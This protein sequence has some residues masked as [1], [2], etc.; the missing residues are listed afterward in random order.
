MYAIRSYYVPEADDKLAAELIMQIMQEALDTLK[1]E[2]EE[3]KY[4]NY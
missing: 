1:I 3:G 4:D 2:L